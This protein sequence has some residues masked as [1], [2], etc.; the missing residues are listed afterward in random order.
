[1]GIDT[2]ACEQFRGPSA[3]DVDLRDVAGAMLALLEARM[4]SAGFGDVLDEAVEL[5]RAWRAS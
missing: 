1:M 3:R 5:T 2:P 4:C